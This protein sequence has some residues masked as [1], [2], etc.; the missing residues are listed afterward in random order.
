ML[1]TMHDLAKPHPNLLAQWTGA[2]TYWQLSATWRSPM[3]LTLL[4]LGLCGAVV[5]NAHIWISGMTDMGELAL[6]V[7]VTSP[8]SLLLLGVLLRNTANYPQQHATHT[9]VSTASHLQGA[10]ETAQ[11]QSSRAK[12][13]QT[14]TETSNH[15]GF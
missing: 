3:E 1:Y 8:G 11:G 2:A 14:Q 7:P 4:K 15:L 5:S 9:T 13:A 10:P 6:R 12:E